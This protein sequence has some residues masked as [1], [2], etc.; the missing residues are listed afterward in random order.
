M[1]TKSF[2]SDPLSS[3]S[4]G[5]PW[6]QKA[7]SPVVRVQNCQ[8]FLFFKP[9]LGQN[10][11][12]HAPH[13]SRNIISPISAVPILFGFI[14]HQFSSNIKR[15]VSWIANQT[16]TWNLMIGVSHLYDLHSWLDVKCQVSI[17]T[18]IS[19]YPG[20]QRGQLQLTFRIIG[21]H[22]RSE[23]GNADYKSIYLFCCNEQRVCYTRNCSLV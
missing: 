5:V 15:H 8:R 7:T 21:E 11:A 12:S 2:H 10:I 23:N 3:P 19:S 4:Q 1:G 16:S 18:S 17:G 13:V 9:E 22:A 14:F 20:N 6:T